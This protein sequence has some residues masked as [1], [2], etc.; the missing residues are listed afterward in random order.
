VSS[1]STRIERVRKPK[2]CPACG[3]NSVASIMYGMPAF[4]DD[5][6]R[7]I[8]EGSITLGGCCITEDDPTWECTYCGIMIFRRNT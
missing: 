3:A 6:E 1:Y 4:S 5:L 2:K 7:K 8:N